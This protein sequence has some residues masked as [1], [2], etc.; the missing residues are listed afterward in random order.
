MPAGVGPRAALAAV[1][2]A[3]VPRRIAP[4][5]CVG[6]PAVWPWAC[7]GLHTMVFSEAW[8][9]GREA[10]PCGPWVPALFGFL[11]VLPPLATV[12]GRSGSLPITDGIP[13]LTSL[14][15]S[16]TCIHTVPP[17][18]P[19][20]SHE[21]CASPTGTETH[22]VAMTTGPPTLNPIAHMSVI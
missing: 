13:E 10:G 11:G 7:R 1:T 15:I 20:C 2:E 18:S 3:S 19:W 22:S 21:R 6:R 17:H 5:C 14:P 4:L 9:S 8:A 16:T 12:Q